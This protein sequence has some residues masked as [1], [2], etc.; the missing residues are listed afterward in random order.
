MKKLLSLIL[1]FG[2]ASADQGPPVYQAIGTVPGTGIACDGNR[3]QI[4]TQ[5]GLIWACQSG[6]W[7]KLYDP[8]QSFLLQRA[9]P[10]YPNAFDVSGLATG[11]MLTTQYMGVTGVKAAN[12][13]TNM[14][15]RSDNTSGAW[16]CSAVNLSTDTA[17]TALPATKGGTGLQTTTQ[18]G[19]LY[20]GVTNTIGVTAA[21]A[22]GQVALSAGTGVPV[23]ADAQRVIR[24]T[25]D[26]T[27]ATTGLTS[28]ALTWT[29]PAVV[30]RSGFDCTLMVKSDG[31][32]LGAQIAVN[33]SVAPTTITYG[34]NW[35]TAAGT[36][37][38]TSGTHEFVQTITNATALGPTVGLVDY[39]IWRL[40]GVIV[41][42]ASA[43]TV[44]VQAKASGAGTITI[45]SGSYCQYYVL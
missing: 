27:N 28:T 18:G 1:L 8:S 26:Y 38:S 41:H 36:A 25:A 9:D 19:L 6:A 17:A 31:T 33:S 11:L 45:G 42:T 13:C 21:G 34:L 24:L 15:P 3:V 40:A 20:G 35:V 16:T 7:K 5:Y 23:W 32:G 30:S 2:L 44:T 4:E 12:T 10:T 43:S 37:P 22:A 29:S 39:T 14:F